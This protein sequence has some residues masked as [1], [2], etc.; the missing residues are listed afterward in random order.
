MEKKVQ[1]HYNTINLKE[2]IFSALEKAGKNLD[3]LSLKDLALIDQLHTGGTQATLALLERANLKPGSEILDAGCGL[4]GS[5]RLMAKKF[6]HVVT[7]IDLSDQFIEAARALTEK[8]RLSD[9]V[10]FQGGSIL[11][12]P[13]QKQSFDAILC[14]HMLM[15]IQHK[16][17]AFQAFHRVLGNGG[18]L[19]IHEITKGEDNP[20]LYPVPWAK[21]DAISFIESWESMESLIEKTGF[22]RQTFSDETQNASNWW[23]KAKQAADK[24]NMLTKE[25]GPHLVF[26]DTA[27]VFGKNMSFNFKWDRIKAV[28]AVFI[29]RG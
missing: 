21:E 9:Q 5:S 18:K 3:C 23:A 1:L 11:D 26:G 12:L 19:M 28:E 25:L 29:K 8:T 4:G 22:E 14:Q 16:E 27:A 17:K 6:E 24:N 2:K 13:F 15:N 20:I 7:G 10:Y